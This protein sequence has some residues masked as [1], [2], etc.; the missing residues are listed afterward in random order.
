MFYFSILKGAD[1]GIESDIITDRM[2]ERC[3]IVFDAIL[4]YCISSL[5]IESEAS[6]QGDIDEDIFCT[7]LYNDETHTFEQVCFYLC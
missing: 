1:H 6:M 2:Q 5:K 4:Q 7:V 3:N